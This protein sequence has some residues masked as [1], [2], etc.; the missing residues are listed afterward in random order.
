M[1]GWANQT[2]SGIWH[3][4][5][6]RVLIDQVYPG[7][8]DHERH[9][10]YLLDAFVDPRYI[11]VDGKPAFYV[12][13][14][15]EIP[16]VVQMTALW[17]RM[18]RDAGLPGIYLLA[19]DMFVDRARGPIHG[20][21]AMVQVNL[22][23][24]R[25]RGARHR[26]EGWIHRGVVVHDYDAWLPRFVTEDVRRPDVHPCLIPNWDNTPRSGRR[27]MVLAGSSPR[28]FRVQV[29]RACELI[30]H[31]PRER[32]LIFVK[33]WNEWAEGNYLEPDREN[34]TAYLEALASEVVPERLPRTDLGSAGALAQAS[35]SRSEERWIAERG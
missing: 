10:R 12:Y 28:S 26:V 19:E 5:P 3:G 30:R 4:E 13:R 32:R 27:G 25:Q 9:F 31:K 18:A 24:L 6:S 23:R 21:D 7:I 8:E 15:R 1:L 35:G 14:P 17:R 34:G 2:W 11:R 22:P 33:S 29:R 16:D 20:F